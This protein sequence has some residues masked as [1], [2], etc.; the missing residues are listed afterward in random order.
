M[1]ETYTTVLIETNPGSFPRS[2]TENLLM[3]TLF[4]EMI[5]FLHR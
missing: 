5:I 1:D 2:A 3:K 4:D